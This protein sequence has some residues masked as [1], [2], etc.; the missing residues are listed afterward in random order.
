MHLELS[1]HIELNLDIR[2]YMT[3]YSMY[4]VMSERNIFKYLNN[5]AQIYS[6]LKI[7]GL[8]MNMSDLLSTYNFYAVITFGYSFA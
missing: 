8:Q 5:S 1:G 2:K 4:L 6:Y 7:F 3:N